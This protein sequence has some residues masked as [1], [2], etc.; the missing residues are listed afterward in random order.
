MGTCNFE[1]ME[2]DM[3]LV[4]G[5]LGSFDDYKESYEE[6]SFDDCEY[7]EDMFWDDLN[8]EFELAEEMAEE[9]S[10]SLKYHEVSVQSGYYNGFQFV[11]RETCKG[12]DLDKDSPYCIDNEDAQYWYGICRSKVLRA[13]EAEKRKIRKWLEKAGEAPMFEI[14]VCVGV[15]SNGEAVYTT[16]SNRSK[17]YE[18]ATA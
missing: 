12:G 4:C 3:P 13:A 7:T 5:G 18:A 9:F 10:D 11:V 15:F 14:L 6:N 16:R 2:Y 1:P 17:L 8:F